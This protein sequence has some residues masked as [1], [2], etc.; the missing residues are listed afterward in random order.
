VAYLEQ[1]N[2][3]RKAYIN[4]RWQS[5]RLIVLLWALGKIQDLPDS[6]TQCDTSLFKSVLPPFASPWLRFDC[7]HALSGRGD[8]RRI[9][10]ASRRGASL[11]Q[12]TQPA[13][14]IVTGRP[15]R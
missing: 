4:F 5:E 9:R 11:L 1:T 6:A 2:P 14:L 10:W 8:D 7:R 3:P 13:V 12:A 15:A